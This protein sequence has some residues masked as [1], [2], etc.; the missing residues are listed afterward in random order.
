MIGKKRSKNPKPQEVVETKPQV[1]Q[2]SIDTL[3]NVNWDENPEMRDLINSRVPGGV[4][5]VEALIKLLQE[6][7]K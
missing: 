2:T 1:Q 5:S 7:Q 3:K 6:Q 4:A